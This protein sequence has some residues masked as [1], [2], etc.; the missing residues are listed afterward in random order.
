M[1]SPHPVSPRHRPPSSNNTPH[2]SSG[3]AH[4]RLLHSSRQQASTVPAADLL[5][6]GGVGTECVLVAGLDITDP[7]SLPPALAPC[8]AADLSGLAPAFIGSA[9]H[10]PLRD[11]AAVYAKLLNDAGVPAELSNEGT[12]VHG[13]VSFALIIPAAAEATN[14]GLAALKAALH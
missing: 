4:F 7:A 8:N 13:Y 14:R 3:V 10:D 5:F 12:L 11:D 6:H 1:E 9:E 2:R